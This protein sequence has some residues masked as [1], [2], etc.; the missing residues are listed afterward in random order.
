MSQ[1]R[2][3][4]CMKW[5]A[6]YAPDYVNVLYRATCLHLRKP[7]RFVCLTDD[8]TGLLPEIETFPIPD[9]G[10]S[11]NHYQAGAW[12]KLGIFQRDLYGLTG[13]GLFIDLD[14]VITGPL[15][16]FFDES[17]D[18]IT[19]GLHQ[20]YPGQKEDEVGTGIFAFDIGESAHLLEIFQANINQHVDRYVIEQA[21]VQGEHGDVTYW[22]EG[23]VIS[24]KR[25]LRQPLG[26]DRLKGPNRPGA[27]A[28]VLAFHGR[29]RPID[30][31]NPP[32]GN[33]DQFPH[34]GRGRV[35]WMVDYWTGHGGTIS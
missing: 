5:G 8:A 4:F 10:L 22:P 35:D 15:D 25:H 21:F 3:V 11:P 16:P 24:F 6:L 7:F 33:W 28:K 18:L 26:L 14:T 30:L 27:D 32:T 1:D 13:R 19:I 9:I 12:P 23:W 34:Y 2:V 31:I 17:G 20:W 29:P